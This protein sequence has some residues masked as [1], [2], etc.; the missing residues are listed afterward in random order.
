MKGRYAVCGF[1]VLGWEDAH[2][3]VE[4]AE[5]TGMPIILQAGPGAR[6]H[7]PVSV[8]GAMFRHLADQ[9][10]V[11]IVCHIDHART[12]DECREA[13]DHGFTS[14]MID[15]SS[16]PLGENICLTAE[17]VDLARRHHLSVEGEIGAVGYQNGKPSSL[18]DPD[19]AERFVAETG[20]DALAISVGNVH[21]QTDHDAVI[22]R[23]RLREIEA[24]T[25]VPLVL[26]GGS[27]INPATRS[28]LAH[29][30]RVKKFN[31]GTELRQE[32]GQS[33][34]A[35]LQINPQEFDRL[36]ILSATAMP[37]KEHA[38]QLIRELG[39]AV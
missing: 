32:F 30:T 20:I 9:A 27:G 16:L 7:M 36:T 6:R 5:E 31:I 37:L 13:I 3:Y 38:V 8:W 39:P 18:T 12:Y 28:L 33:L 2:A 17:V 14:L 23:L 22:D 34:R 10:S 1:V 29:E 4:A 11:P 26:H 21:L 24:R 35:F 19:E 25:D 15:G